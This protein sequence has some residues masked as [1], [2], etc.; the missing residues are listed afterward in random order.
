M[1]EFKT[2]SNYFEKFTQRNLEVI[3][4]ALKPKKTLEIGTHEGTSIIDLCFRN[5]WSNY[6]EAYC[7]DGWSKHQINQIFKKFEESNDKFFKKHFNTS[8]QFKID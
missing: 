6:V 8:N 4:P 3:L 7:I 5:N 1:N 2:N